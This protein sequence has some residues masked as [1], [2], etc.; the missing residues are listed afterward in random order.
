MVLY[1][2]ACLLSLPQMRP[3]QA[4]WGLFYRRCASLALF[5]S[6]WGNQ[7]PQTPAKGYLRRA[8]ALSNSAE[9]PLLGCD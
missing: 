9:A 1:V 3:V 7:F 4:F 8:R 6:L 2:P 5:K